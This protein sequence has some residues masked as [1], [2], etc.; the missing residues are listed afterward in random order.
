MNSTLPP[1]L[2]RSRK[3]AVLPLENG[4]HLSVVEF[5]VRY[6]AAKALKKCQLIEGTV[7]LPSPVR[8]D[9]HAEPVLDTKALLKRDGAKLVAALG[10]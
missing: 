8:A 4:E 9:A 2:K 6:E 10:A 3:P 1:P 5:L 7:Y